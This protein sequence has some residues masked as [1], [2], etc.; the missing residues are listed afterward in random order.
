MAPFERELHGYE[1]AI[2]DRAGCH[3]EAAAAA[4]DAIA[5]STAADDPVTEIW[6]RLVAAIIAMRTQ[7]FDEARAQ[8]EAARRSSVSAKDQW[9]AALSFGLRA[10]S[11]HWTAAAVTPGGI[12]LD[13]ASGDR[14]A[15]AGLGDVGELAL[16][17]QAAA[18]VAAR[19]GRA[20]VAGALLDATPATTEMTV[21]PSPFDEPTRAA[22]DSVLSGQHGRQPSARTRCP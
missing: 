10:I 4:A 7:E 2:L 18:T 21:L 20:D 6:A 12:A 14:A 3:R 11:Q 8:L 13:V 16:A 5:A 22:A 1:A 17:L 19:A 15:A 9:W